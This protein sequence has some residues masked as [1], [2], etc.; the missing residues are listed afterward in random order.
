MTLAN[1][2]ALGKAF[3]TLGRHLLLE[4]SLGDRARELATLRV[5]W[6][7]KA[8]YEWHH[9]VR[10]GQSIGLTDAE[11]EAVKGEPSNPIWGELDACVLSATDQL[12]QTG[13]IEDAT[14]A[15]L[16]RLLEQRQMMDLVFTVGQYVMVSWAVADPRM[17]HPAANA[18]TKDHER[19]NGYVR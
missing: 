9:H 14:W 17:R 2:P 16:S 5:A 18:S 19:T 10:F 6:R 8:D 1:Y 7:Y 4:S 11:I 13:G 12:C 15:E 3:Y